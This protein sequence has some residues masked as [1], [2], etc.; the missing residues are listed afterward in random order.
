VKV[1]NR[2]EAPKA[3]FESTKEELKKKMLPK[4]QDDALTEWA[5][6]LRE[7]AKIEINQALFA[8]K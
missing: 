3:Q 1:K 2:V 6:G 8:D 7:K 5:K 4:K